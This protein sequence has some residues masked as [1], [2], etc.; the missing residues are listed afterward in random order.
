M[1]GIRSKT[2]SIFGM[3]ISDAQMLAACFMILYL[4]LEAYKMMAGD[5]KLEI[6]PLLRPFALG[7]I[8]VFWISPNSHDSINTG[9]VGI[10]SYPSRVLTNTS[11]GMYEAQLDKVELLSRNRYA[12]IDSIATELM[13]TSLQIER[14]EEEQRDKKWYELGIDLSAIGDRIAGM[15]LY[16]I[17]RIKMVGFQ[18]IEWIVVTIWQV[19]IYLVFFLQIIFEGILI[20]LGPL[21]FAF[22]ILPAFRDAWIQWLARYLSVSLY[23][24]IGYIVLS[25][26]LA[27][28]DY[29]LTKEI[30]IM[31]QAL[32]S[33]SAF[34]MYTAYSSGGIN[35]F[36]V[37]CLVG[38][39]SM[40]TIPF[41][42]TWIINTTGA[43]HAVAAVTG[44]TMAVIKAGQKV[45]SAGT[46]VATGGIVK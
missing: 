1:E 13:S 11:K 7:L 28:M 10:I 38:A 26:S 37:T 31:Q 12:L 29:A 5:K 16:V 44:G 14:A 43:G 42:S 17:G 6:I 45:V 34:I 22:S 33:E 27:I 24:C 18:I 36:C 4:G 35:A 9:F 23:S 20:T 41:I 30:D 32:K 15:W 3:F 21:S 46:T 2:G 25:I 8:L 19:C 40:L 39:I